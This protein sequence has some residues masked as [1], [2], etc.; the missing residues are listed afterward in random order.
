MSSEDIT[1]DTFLAKAKAEGGARIYLTGDVNIWKKPF[2]VKCTDKPAYTRQDD[3]LSFCNDH[4]HATGEVLSLVWESFTY[5]SLV[6]LVKIGGLRTS[7]T[8]TP[9]LQKK[10]GE[11]YPNLSLLK[12]CPVGTNMFIPFSLLK[13]KVR[14]TNSSGKVVEKRATPVVVPQYKVSLNL[15]NDIF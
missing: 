5:E 6:D 14:Y 7:Y 10:E 4:Y 13:F 11:P 8:P 1:L 15:K 12:C 3:A 2:T 9:D